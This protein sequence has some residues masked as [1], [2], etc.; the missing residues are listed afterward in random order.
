MRINRKVKKRPPLRLIQGNVPH[1]IS[2][3]SVTII[4]APEDKPPFTAEAVVFEED[5]FLVLSADRTVLEPH[6][7]PI[8]I[9]T[10]AF[11]ISPKKTGSVMVKGKHPFCLFAIIHDLNQEPSWKEE[12]I[13]RALDG[14]FQEVESRNI[15]SL[16]LPFLGTLH[17]TLQK[18]RFVKLFGC[19][20]KRMAHNRLKRI[21]LML[22]AGTSDTIITLLDSE[23]GR[24]KKVQKRK[25]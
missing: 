14:I 9:M 18:H 21:W 23:L 10:E 19:A 6:E 7:H 17:G 1:K 13:A 24:K 25:N 16:A 4:A 12:W 5:T 22:P 15:Q 20:L 2:V 11:N 8:R 3:G